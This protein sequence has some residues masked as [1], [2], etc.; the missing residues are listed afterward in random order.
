MVIKHPEWAP[1]PID[2]VQ[3]LMVARSSTILNSPNI[4]HDNILQAHE[5]IETLEIY[6]QRMA[7]GCFVRAI[8][9]FYT[10]IEPD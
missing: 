5:R 10:T 2:R 7:H 4:V 3:L 9:T 1:I 6:S 8:G